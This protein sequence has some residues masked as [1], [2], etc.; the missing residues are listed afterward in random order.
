MQINPV[1]P[2]RIAG[3]SAYRPAGARPNP[4]GTSSPSARAGVIALS[5]RAGEARRVQATAATAPDVRAEKV[6]PIKAQVQ[7]GTYRV[8]NQALAERLIDVL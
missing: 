4:A 7:S 2:S 5:E 6:A 3:I 8:D 1:G